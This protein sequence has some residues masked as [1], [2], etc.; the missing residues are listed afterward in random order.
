MSGESLECIKRCGEGGKEGE[1]EIDREYATITDFFN[2]VPTVYLL[3]V[4]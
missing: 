2:I 4:Y 1:I 3:I